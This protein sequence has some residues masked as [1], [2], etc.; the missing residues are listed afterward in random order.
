MVM[1]QRLFTILAVTTATT[2]AHALP[3]KS[4]DRSGWIEA[5]MQG[6]QAAFCGVQPK[7]IGGP[8]DPDFTVNQVGKDWDA[9]D[10]ATVKIYDAMVLADALC[11]FPGNPDLQKALAPRWN[12]FLKFYKLGAAD[13]ADIAA[14]MDRS[15]SETT[16]PAPPKEARF[17]DLD[18]RGQAAFAKDYVETAYGMTFM[19]YAELI[20][21]LPSPSEHLRAAFV[22]QCVDSY[23]GSL[24]R[25]AICKSDALSLDR[26]K[27][28][29]ELAAKTI[30]PHKRLDEKLRF[31][32]LQGAVA[33]RAAKIADEIKKDGGVAKVIDEIPA[34]AQ[35]KWAEES[36][37]YKAL[38]AWT[39]KRLD[40][41]RAQNKKLLDG[42]EDELI[43]HLGTYL[44]T[45][46]PATPE[47]LK[48]AFRDNI[49][50]QL[51]QAAEACFV[52]NEVVQ[53]FWADKATGFAHYVG[54]RTATWYALAGAKIEFDTNRGND[55]IGLPRP[56]I[57]Y[58][59]TSAAQSNGTIASIKDTGAGIEVTFKK[60]SWKEPVCK[61]WKETNTID[62]IDLKTGKL[63]Y[64][65]VCTSRGY[66]TRTEQ[67]KPVTVPA[68]Y[69]AGVKAGIAAIFVRGEDGTGYPIA[70]YAD[71][72][73]TK[74]VGAYGV[75]Y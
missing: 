18:A 66:E 29:K 5:S 61:A 6:P 13:Y 41:S 24:G 38:L 58:A 69:A 54:P 50:S 65:E 21:S 36:G 33:A 55:P 3:D 26:A 11:K 1:S 32:Q 71:A 4:S 23:A 57:L 51:G 47:D 8:A 67:A 75:T 31:V 20:D 7:K 12:A 25:W 63:K 70:I 10:I 45:T 52:R 2:I 49:G 35:K 40:D 74:L 34:A 60:E 22:T 19:S 44:K 56:V 68:K 27:F 14:V 72:K 28:D 16:E 9:K 73:R 39:S 42:C 48:A 30:D 15:R 53:R 64:R 43:T 17:A 46:K 37:T 59:N 62:G